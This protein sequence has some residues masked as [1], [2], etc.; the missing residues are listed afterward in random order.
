MRA[1]VAA[2]VPPR[3]AARADARLQRHGAVIAR[4]ASDVAPHDA[5]AALYRVAEYV[6]ALAGD[7]FDVT[8]RFV[9]GDNWQSIA[10]AQ[11]TMPAVHVR[12]AQ[13]RRRDF[14]QQGPWVE[15]GNLHLLDGQ[16]F[17]VLGDNGGAT[18]IHE[19]SFH[20]SRRSI[21]LLN[22]WND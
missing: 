21:F 7:I 20:S 15:L 22:D 1:L 17:V 14:Y 9:A 11:R 5:L 13:G 2:V 16:R 19:E 8:A 3:R 6:R 10:L 12:A 4:A 18:G